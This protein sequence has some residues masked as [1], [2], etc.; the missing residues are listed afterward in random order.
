LVKE[1]T[2]LVNFNF[3]KFDLS[4]ASDTL[5]RLVA[6]MKT[7]PAKKCELVG[8]TDPEGDVKYNLELSNKRVSMVKSYLI[9]H[10]VSEKRI[11]TAYHGK[12]DILVQ[13]K[14][15]N[16]NLKNRRVEI[17]LF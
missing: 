13:S 7:N 1:E 2:F 10:G 16:A 11:I 4:L 6:A 9:S 14:D 8:H 15:R 17:R 12:A 3:G 5:K